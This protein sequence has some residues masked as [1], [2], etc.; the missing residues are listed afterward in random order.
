MNASRRAAAMTNN[1]D[2]NTAVAWCVAHFEDSNFND[3]LVF[4]RSDET[5]SLG[6]IPHRSLTTMMKSAVKEARQYSKRGLRSLIS[7][8]REGAERNV[9]SSDF[10]PEA[11]PAN[12]SVGEKNDDSFGWD[13]DDFDFDDG[14]K[15]E[16]PAV[17]ATEMSPELP[18]EDE[19]ACGI[20]DAEED[21]ATDSSEAR[22]EESVEEPRALR[23]AAK[24]VAALSAQMSPQPSER[25][26]TTKPFQPSSTNPALMSTAPTRLAPA[27]SS[28]SA[29]QEP[30]S[31]AG[32]WDEDD[33]FDG[34]FD[35]DNDLAGTLESEAD[36]GT[37]F[38]DAP[39]YVRRVAP[40]ASAAPTPMKTTTKLPPPSL[41]KPDT[42]SRVT[43]G[44]ASNAGAVS[45]VTEVQP[46][47]PSHPLRPRRPTASTVLG[48]IKSPMSA[49]R[50]QSQR[51]GGE[52]RKRMVEEGRRL[53]RE[54]RVVQSSS[55]S[56]SMRPTTRSM[57]SS[58]SGKESRS[59]T[60]S[61]PIPKTGVNITD[62]TERQRL[63]LEGRRLLE[64][65]RKAKKNEAATDATAK[66]R[67]PPPPRPSR[68][69]TTQAKAAPCPPSPSS[70]TP[71]A[72]APF[73]EATKKL[74]KTDEGWDDFDNF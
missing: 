2:F 69:P 64:E 5:N 8:R 53:L 43:N 55:P 9:S 74:D 33:D 52:E 38:P 4:I 6:A 30:T 23:E 67:P 27:N 1:A 28:P 71:S 59:S 72:P 21:N 63:V 40:G 65:A 31:E 60:T 50:E 37:I 57:T 11:L 44:A 73:Q 19:G 34:M 7:L 48:S 45:A 24:E 12:R 46:P 54:K 16:S 66:A 41:P 70:A 47:T 26:Q 20:N 13:D 29:P 49:V 56:S 25:L 22:N 3:P 36:Q 14:L 15:D 42:S 39:S 10:L 18:V 61:R 35:E 68:T 58:I 62:P 32:G 51:L 17:E